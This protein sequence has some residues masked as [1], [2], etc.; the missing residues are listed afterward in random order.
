MMC[1]RQQSLMQ[2]VLLALR[3]EGDGD[4]LSTDCEEK[5]DSL[6]LTYKTQEVQTSNEH[7][8]QKGNKEPQK[9]KTN[10][11]ANRHVLKLPPI[12]TAQVLQP[13]IQSASST[14]IR[15][16]KSRVV[17]LQ[18]QLSAA[19]TETRLLKSLLHRHTVALQHFQ[20]S[21]SSI[22]QIL[23]KHSNETR[24][25]QQLL[26]E[27]RACRESLARQFQ[28]TEINLRSTKASLQHLQL[29][30]Q[31]HSLLPREEL[32]LRLDRASAQ[33]ESKDRRIQDLEKN[34]ELSQAS[35]N[36]QIFAEQRKIN[37]AKKITGY[38]QEQIYHL[39][40]EI[41]D[42]ER[43]LETHNIYSQRFLK[44]S[45]KKGSKSKMVQTDPLVR[46][47]SAAGTLLELKYTEKQGP[48][49]PVEESLAIDNPET[50]LSA[51]LTF[52]ENHPEETETC[53][54]NQK[55]ERSANLTLEENQPEECAD[56]QS[57]ADEGKEY[58]SEGDYAEEE[59]ALEAP[60]ASAEERKTEETSYILEKS[61]NANGGDRQGYTLLKIRSSY[62]FKQT[63]ENM[64]IGKPAYS[65]C[66]AYQ[67]PMKME[68]LS[69]EGSPELCLSAGKSRKGVGGSPQGK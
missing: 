42:R 29:L 64:H 17:D 53:A 61:L 18:Q 43:E 62:T 9:Q 1:V 54:E 49:N 58:L 14:C 63:I 31:D 69:G 5:A 44:G 60:E 59:E 66:S 22:S 28:S 2:Q 56:E 10:Q 11:N 40:K 26:S 47:S 65:I 8:R 6:T 25:L 45:P 33:L 4:A 12:K 57:S 41:Q 3:E 50:G 19:G 37:E 16:L 15:D 34:L 48:Y 67:S 32:S 23:A 24:V 36:R 21:E 13:R 51:D 55:S 52:E 30:S 35:F 39:N 7:R 68:T 38:L 20:D 27:T 46:L